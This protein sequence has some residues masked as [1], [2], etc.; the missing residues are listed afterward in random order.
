[1][2]C[3]ACL[4]FLKLYT[5]KYSPPFF[6]FAPLPSSAGKS[7]TGQNLMSEIILI[8]YLLVYRQ[9]QFDSMVASANEAV[10]RYVGYLSTLLTA[11]KVN[12]F[13][14]LFRK[15]IVITYSAY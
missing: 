2:L 7:K 1:M 4:A 11:M 14:L 12:E 10:I 3:F 8:T 5:G 13:A 6:F 15:C 9:G